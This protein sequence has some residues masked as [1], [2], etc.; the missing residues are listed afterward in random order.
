VWAHGLYD[1]LEI[2]RF[3]RPGGLTGRINQ[4]AASNTRLSILT[5]VFEFVSLGA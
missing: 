1:F 3:C 5:P 4:Q 2:H